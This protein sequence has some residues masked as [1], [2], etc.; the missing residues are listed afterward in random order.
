[1]DRVQQRDHLRNVVAVAGSQQDGSRAPRPPV[2][3]GRSTGPAFRQARLGVY[4]LGT[5]LEERVPI[6]LDLLLDLLDVGAV[7]LPEQVGEA[8]L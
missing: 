4:R 8:L 7:L 6:C 5:A 2:I 3:S 1:M